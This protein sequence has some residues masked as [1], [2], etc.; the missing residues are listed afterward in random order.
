MIL[1]IEKREGNDSGKCILFNYFHLLSHV[2]AQVV[3]SVL[4]QMSSKC[5]ISKFYFF[6]LVF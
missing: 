4:W 6:D 5:D 2:P 3:G 1:L